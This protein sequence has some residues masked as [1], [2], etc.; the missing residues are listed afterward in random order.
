MNP[1][2]SFVTSAFLPC[3]MI[4]GQKVLF[5]VKASS[6]TGLHLSLHL[7]LWNELWNMYPAWT[8]PS[9]TS[10]GTPYAKT[11]DKYPVRTIQILGNGQ[12][13]SLNKD[14]FRTSYQQNLP[15]ELLILMHSPGNKMKDLYFLPFYWV[16]LPI[17]IYL[18]WLC[19]R[20]KD[21]LKLSNMNY[22]AH[23]I[24]S[25][26]NSIKTQITISS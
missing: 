10:G 12:Q 11:E 26:V 21:Q 19:L 16:L 23:F 9:N 8:D 5:S 3:V 2:T 17:N 13:L 4:K 14:I 6:S 22:N 20:K 1:H 15:V 7:P 18:G 24:P 25:K